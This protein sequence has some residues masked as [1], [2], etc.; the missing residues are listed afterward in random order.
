VLFLIQEKDRRIPEDLSPGTSNVAIL[1]TDRHD[2]ATFA[3]DSA[4]RRRQCG[5]S[6]S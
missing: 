1:S 5:K 4:R 3:A 6:K 2:K